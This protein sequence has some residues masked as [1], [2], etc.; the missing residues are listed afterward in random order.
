MDAKERRNQILNLL[1]A[2]G[3]AGK[4]LSATALSK[5]FGVSRQIIVG[6]VA[7]LRA[8]GEQ[9]SSTARGY[10]FQETPDPTP[11]FGYVGLVA[12][13]HSDDRLAEELCCIADYGGCTIDVIIEHPLY[14]Q[15]CGIL[16]LRSR[17][18]AEQFAAKVAEGKGTPLSA[19]TDGIH[20]HHI[21]CHD[22]AAFLRI[23]DALAAKKILLPD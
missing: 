23:R 10:I 8:A 6:D 11:D 19:L 2:A 15:L 20:L 17:F 9:I 16:D 5:Q 13:R 1:K 4:P 22:E 21:G 18:D 3:D 14:G 12:C 7:L